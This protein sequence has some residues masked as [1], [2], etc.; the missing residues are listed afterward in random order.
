LCLLA[1]EPGFF[2]CLSEIQKKRKK[3]GLQLL[4]PFF[5]SASGEK[6]RGGQGIAPL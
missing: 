1:R 5:E 3:I 6:R 4:G 2:L